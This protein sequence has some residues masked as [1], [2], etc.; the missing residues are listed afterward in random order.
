MYK[1]PK[2]NNT[3]SLQFIKIESNQIVRVA[4][5]TVSCFFCV[6]VHFI[7]KK[8]GTTIFQ[9]HK[10]LYNRLNN[11]TLIIS[12]FVIYNSNN[13]HEK[14]IRKCSVA[15][16]QRAKATEVY[17]EHEQID[18]LSRIKH[19]S[20]CVQNACVVQL[21]FNGIIFVCAEKKSHNY[22]GFNRVKCIQ[23]ALHR[24]FF[25]RK[26]T[27]E[28]LFS[29]FPKKY[30]D[31]DDAQCYSNCSREVQ[32]S[33]PF[34]SFPFCAVADQ[35]LLVKGLY[36]FRPAIII[37]KLLVLASF[38][39][40]F[41]DISHTQTHTKTRT[42]CHRNA[43]RFETMCSLCEFV[44]AQ[45]TLCGFAIYFVAKYF[46]RDWLVPEKLCV[47]RAKLH[48][49]WSASPRHTSWL[50]GTSRLPVLLL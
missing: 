6:C 21:E 20:M 37:V 10:K 49:K 34:I 16:C 4:Y 14:C 5:K 48:L 36:A 9:K 32:Q 41:K 50:L 29:S 11:S 45:K 22:N 23:F 2:L 38:Y 26:K 30:I 46:G 33:L 40:P 13:I 28:F 12:A 17:K 27:P 39:F 31:I 15:R 24:K 19:V 43:V 44:C 1:R 25:R 47:W 35:R 3:D 7:W 18:E 42:Q 8:A